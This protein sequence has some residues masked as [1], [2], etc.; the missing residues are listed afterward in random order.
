MH[1]YTFVHLIFGLLF[2]GDVEVNPSEYLYCEPDL[3]HIA[4]KPLNYR[5][6]E[7]SLTP[8]NSFFKK[9]SR[10]TTVCFLILNFV[11]SQYDILLYMTK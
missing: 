3:P 4:N 9:V 7:S 6:S 10:H 1:P 11:R 8:N 2:H 5:I